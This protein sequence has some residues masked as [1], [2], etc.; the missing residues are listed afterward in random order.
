MEYISSIIIFSC[1]QKKQ[2][3]WTFISAVFSFF[4]WKNR[5]ISEK[6]KKIDSKIE[7]SMRLLTIDGDIVFN[8]N[9]EKF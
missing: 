9:T 2:C 3:F 1:R 4:F 8:H 5:N 7:N 6:F